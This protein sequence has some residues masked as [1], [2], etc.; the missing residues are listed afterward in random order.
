MLSIPG[1]EMTYNDSNIAEYKGHF[2]IGKKRNT[3]T[4]YS[5][6]PSRNCYIAYFPMY[7]YEQ[8]KDQLANTSIPR[9]ERVKIM[10]YHSEFQLCNTGSFTS[11]K[12]IECDFLFRGNGTL[13]FFPETPNGNYKIVSLFVLCNNHQFALFAVA[14]LFGSV[15]P[16]YFLFLFILYKC[17]ME[18]TDEDTNEYS[19]SMEDNNNRNLRSM[20]PLARFQNN[21]ELSNNNEGNDSNYDFLDELDHVFIF[22]PDYDLQALFDRMHNAPFKYYFKFAKIIS[23]QFKKAYEIFVLTFDPNLNNTRNA[24][25]ANTQNTNNTACL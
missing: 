19:D 11:Q 7:E 3:F 21:A 8:F 25:M 2:E 17:I 13:V 15:F 18:N 9:S 10:R 20:S 14:F 1:L 22:G 23:K 16:T 4:I 24:R 12:N 6:A 5:K